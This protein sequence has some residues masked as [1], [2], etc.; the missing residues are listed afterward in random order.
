MRNDL[1]IYEK[2]GDQ[3]WDPG[4]S[5]FRSLQSVNV[6]REGLIREWFGDRL[7]GALVVDLG[8]GGGLL[9]EPLAES[10]ARVLGLDLS[11]RSLRT[12]ASRPSTRG[13][14]YV[15]ADLA[16]SPVAGGIADIAILADVLEHVPDVEA[17]VAEAARVL[18]PGGLLYVNTI[19]RTWRAHF[20]AVTV[21]EG[22]KLVP[23][24]THDP[25]L[26]VRPGELCEQAARHGLR[27]RRL[28]GE[29][30][31]LCATARRWTVTL[32]KSRTLSVLYSALF[33][34][35]PLQRAGTP[36]QVD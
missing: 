32:R 12:A 8:C 35:D 28:Q 4:S 6:F 27:S 1:Q 23:R 11:H 19:N 31:A 26:F 7:A 13:R 25:K 5:T 2:N 10:G 15:R 9:A 21:A 16:R 33:Q 36:Q 30:P 14:F 29:A 17:A 20:L 22:L 3:W 18:K 24:G 34:K